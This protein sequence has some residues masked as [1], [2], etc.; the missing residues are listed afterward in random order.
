VKLNRYSYFKNC[1]LPCFHLLFAFSVWWG[2]H[3]PH[4][5]HAEVEDN[6]RELVLYLSPP[7]GPQD[8][9]VGPQ[10]SA[11]GPQDSA[12]GPQEWAQVTRLG[13]GA[14]TDKS[15]HQPSRACQWYLLAFSHF[16]RKPQRH[17]GTVT[18]GC[19]LGMTVTLD[20][21]TVSSHHAFCF[22]LTRLLRKLWFIVV[23]LCG[24]L[25]LWSAAKVFISSF[26]KPWVISSATA[27]VPK[28]PSIS[29]LKY[30]NYIIYTVAV[31]IC[32]IADRFDV[33]EGRDGSRAVWLDCGLWGILHPFLISPFYLFTSVFMQVQL[34]CLD[35]KRWHLF[36][37]GFT[38]HSRLL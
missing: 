6:L 19:I 7:V 31:G 1:L 10:D 29:Q 32:F 20:H 38:L 21:F 33:A 37:W 16:M 17:S 8:S 15:A 12:V 5:V 26:Y 35:W 14:L 3:V 25:S 13:I 9:A 28:P 11:V 24:G 36:H 2:S 23:I 22:S 34:N 4:S 18:S 30:R 27:W